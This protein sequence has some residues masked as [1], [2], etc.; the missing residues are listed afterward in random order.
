MSAI[1]SPSGPSNSL[2]KAANEA[3]LLVDHLASS[4]LRA[5]PPEITRNLIVNKT[6]IQ[7][8]ETLT[9]DQQ[10]DFWLA[11]SAIAQLCDPATVEGITF[12]DKT[13]EPT[14]ALTYPSVKLQ[15]VAALF[16]SVLLQAYAA[17]GTTLTANFDDRY[18]QIWEQADSTDLN[19]KQKKLLNEASAFSASITDWNTIWRFPISAFA[20][21][22]PEGANDP[23]NSDPVE[24][25]RIAVFVLQGF[26]LPLLLGWLGAGVNALRQINDEERLRSITLKKVPGYRVR[27]LL[28]AIGGSTIGLLISSNNEVNGGLMVSPL[29]MAFLVGYN[30]EVFFA[31]IDRFIKHVKDSFSNEPKPDEKPDPAKAPSGSAQEGKP[32]IRV[33]AGT[34]GHSP[35][36]YVAAKPKRPSARVKKASP[37]PE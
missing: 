36:A 37:P 21:A 10:T 3:D 34:N 22:S 17:V 24:E 18:K 30:I 28:G 26:V 33:P 13:S 27:M 14:W 12:A 25:A 29:A 1:A 31:V 9:P 8:G 16:I 7:A 4:S 15:V 6:R 19:Q 32:G 11:Y 20:T 5:L 23:S 35:R 2:L